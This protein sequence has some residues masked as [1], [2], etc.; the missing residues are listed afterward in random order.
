M[1]L[2]SSIRYKKCSKELHQP[3]SLKIL[4]LYPTQPLYHQSTAAATVTITVTVTFTIS[5]T[6]TATVTVTGVVSVTVT[7]TDTVTS[8]IHY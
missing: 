8:V 2:Y 1:R 3:T 5:I 6:V 4:V 7:D